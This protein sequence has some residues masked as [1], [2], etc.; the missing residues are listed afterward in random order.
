MILLADTNIVLDLLVCD[1]LDDTLN[2]LGVTV[3][4]VFVVRDEVRRVCMYSVEVTQRYPVEVLNRSVKF[5][6]DAQPIV[7]PIDPE[8]LAYLSADDGIDAGEVVIFG[9]TRRIRGDYRVATND[10]KALRAVCFAPGCGAVVKRLSGRVLCMERLLLEALAYVGPEAF[11]SR[12][13]IGRKHS[14]AL[15]D[16]FPKGFDES[17]DG[18][19]A[20][21]LRKIGELRAQT[22]ALLAD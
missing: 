6:Y 1:L 20:L 11:A 19:R 7:E 15:A 10:R 12:V 16:T 21:L 17:V 13:K 2:A 4:E 9:V 8:E 14:D 5:A 18:I 3:Q 22:K